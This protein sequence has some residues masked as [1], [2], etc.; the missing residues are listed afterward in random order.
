M[1]LILRFTQGNNPAIIYSIFMQWPKENKL[2]SECL[3]KLNI[4][5]VI[6][7][8]TQSKLNVTNLKLHFYYLKYERSI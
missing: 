8:E 6:M 5:S 3:D 1:I 2:N 4:E 7:L